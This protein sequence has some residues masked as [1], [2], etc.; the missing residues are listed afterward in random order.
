M[1][2]TQQMTIPVEVENYLQVQIF[3]L[4]QRFQQFTSTHKQKLV[5]Q[6]NQKYPLQYKQQWEITKNEHMIWLFCVLINTIARGNIFLSR[7]L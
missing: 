2:T 6:G 5:I 1:A 7:H 3:E 4:F